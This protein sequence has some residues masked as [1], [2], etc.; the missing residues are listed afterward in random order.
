[1]T[2]LGQFI[3]VEGLEGA[4]KTTAIATIKHYL[5]KITIPV[6]V[7]REPGGSLLGEQLRTLLKEKK[8]P[9]PITPLS[10]LLMLYAARV[11]HIEQVILPALNQ[12][13]WV[14]SDRFDLSTYAYQGGG[15]GIDKSIIN[16]LSTLC[17]QR[18]KPNLIFFLD[19]TPS[20]SLERV[21]SRGQALDR[22]EQEPLT[23]FNKVYDAYHDSIA[24]MPEVFLIDA[25]QSMAFV[26]QTIIAHLTQLSGL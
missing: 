8:S 18:V 1:M 5:D 9:E 10:E 15:R 17:L 21:I 4:G 22:I 13:H 2:Q 11:Q 19:I 20:V 23:F 3:V 7:T 12:G 25:N 24:G 26:Q 14:I 6:V 16:T